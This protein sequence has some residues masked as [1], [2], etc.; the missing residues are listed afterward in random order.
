MVK[1]FKI[2]LIAG[3]MLLLPFTTV[4]AKWAYEFVVYNKNVYI[5]TDKKISPELI[6]TKLGQVTKYSLREGTYSGNFSNT[7]PKG[8]KYYEIT[9]V[10]VKELIAVK[11]TDGTFIEAKF[12]AEY[13][14]ARYDIR[15]YLEYFI[16]L[17][18][19]GILI[20]RLVRKICTRSK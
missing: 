17:I 20:W 6:G 3:I 1:M 2:I 10:D 4:Y 18:I 11:D 5:V 8:T 14:G 13:P 19:S 12:E 7:Y 9:G 16:G 15:K